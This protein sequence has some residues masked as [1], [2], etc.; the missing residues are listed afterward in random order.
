MAS[1]FYV[2]RTDLHAYL[3]AYAYQKYGEGQRF[4]G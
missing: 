4:D 1:E 3:Y 2:S